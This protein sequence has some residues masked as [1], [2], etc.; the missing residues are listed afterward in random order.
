MVRGEACKTVAMRENGRI[1]KLTAVQAMMRARKG[2][3]LKGSRIAQKAF[4]KLT[5]ASEAEAVRRSTERM[6]TFIQ[7]K[8]AYEDRVKERAAKGLPP[9]LPH[10]DDIILHRAYG[11]VTITGP[12]DQHDLRWFATWLAWGE[13]PDGQ[14]ALTERA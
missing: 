10:P 9:P 8:H 11:T 4:I 5:M 14:I 1:E 2:A 7:Y 12:R 13:Y 3:G 6:W